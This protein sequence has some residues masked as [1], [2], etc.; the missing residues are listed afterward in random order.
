MSQVK[1]V[2]YAR[3]S[4]EDRLEDTSLSIQNQITNLKRY[5]MSHSY[6]FIKVYADDGYTGGTMNQIGRASCRKEC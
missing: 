2:I 3:L 1:A 4:Q 5:I 6:D